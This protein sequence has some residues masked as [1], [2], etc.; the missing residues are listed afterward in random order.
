MAGHSHGTVPGSSG[1]GS[2]RARLFCPRRRQAGAP[3]LI[4]STVE[5]RP[6][7]VLIVALLSAGMLAGTTASSTSSS[8]SPTKKRHSAKRARHSAQRSV[9]QT[10]TPERYQE[11][12][13]AL[14]S[15]GYYKGAVDGKWNDDSVEA[16]RRFQTDQNLSPD[17][18]IN[19]LSLIAMGLG[20][21]RATSGAVPAAGPSV[22]ASS[23]TPSTPAPSVPSSSSAQP[24]TSAAPVVSSP[25]PPPNP[26]GTHQ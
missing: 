11:I 16:L 12:Q 6:G 20:P 1:E 22:P 5:M 3:S 8:T 13:Q 2:A 23:T 18:R 21:K 10:P 26:A 25:N 9:Q 17:G 7:V 24:P 19:S 14:A 4:E 15:R